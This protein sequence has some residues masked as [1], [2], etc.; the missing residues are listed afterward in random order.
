MTWEQALSTLLAFAVTVGTRLLDR[1]L[2]ATSTVERVAAPVAAEP[3]AP[4]PSPT[5]DDSTTGDP[6]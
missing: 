3:A 1:Y 5:G 4:T 2:P 6:P